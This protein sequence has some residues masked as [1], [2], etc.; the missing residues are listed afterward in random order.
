M[1]PADAHGAT[2][3]GR[4]ATRVGTGGPDRIKT[5]PGDD[6]IVA[7][8]GADVIST[9]AGDDLVCAGFGRDT[10]RAEAVATPCSAAPLGT[11]SMAAPATTP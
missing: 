1:A 2:C 10:V 6:V 3:D 5:G 8:G 7:R 4:T 11:S 9:G